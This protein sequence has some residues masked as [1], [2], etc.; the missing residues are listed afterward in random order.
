[1]KNSAADREQ[2]LMTF[3]EEVLLAI[4]KIREKPE[5]LNVPDATVDEKASEASNPVP[6]APLTIYTRSSFNRL[7][8]G[9]K[10]IQTFLRDL[11]RL[12]KDA[13]MSFLDD[14]QKI[15]VPKS[16]GKKLLWE[17]VCLRAPEMFDIT[18]T[19]ETSQKAFGGAVLTRFHAMM[20][21]KHGAKDSIYNLVGQIDK[22]ARD[23]FRAQSRFCARYMIHAACL[24]PS[25]PKPSEKQLRIV[26]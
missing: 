20:P 13:G 4:A 16:A 24:Y 7:L 23:A 5:L 3:T 18:M 6:D 12:W 17:E 14:Q 22:L 9:A 11:P 10:N 15:T 2:D 26:Y 19:K 8:A 21:G 25:R 1:M